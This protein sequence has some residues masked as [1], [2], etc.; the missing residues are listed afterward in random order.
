MAACVLAA[1]ALVLTPGTP[2]G[3]L[4]NA[5]QTLGRRA[6]A[7]R[8]RVPAAAVQRQGGARTL[9]QRNVAQSLHGVVIAALVMLSIV[10]TASVL[11]PD[12]SGTTI[13]AILGAGCIL[14]LGLGLGCGAAFLFVGRDS[15]GGRSGNFGRATWRMPP[16][17]ALEPA[18]MT[19]LTRLWMI[20]LRL[21]LLV[22]GGL[23]LVRIVQL[24]VSGR[25]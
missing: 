3:L 20:V 7:E 24:A 23:M 12:M 14:A 21:Y 13:L 10:L 2:L 5:V 22:A 11:Y 17:D 9:G 25:A 15:R 18:R 6:A 8:D 19:P 16:L 1:A 4:T